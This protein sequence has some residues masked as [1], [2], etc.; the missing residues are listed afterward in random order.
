MNTRAFLL[1][2][3][4]AGVAIGLFG[5]LPIISLANCILCIWV[6]LGAMLAVWL[7]RKLEGS[8]P[9]LTATQGMLLGLVSG[10]IGAVIVWLLSL[11]T[12]D[13]ASDMI[14]SIATSAGIDLPAGLLGGGFTLIRLV[15]D[16][17][18]YSI[19]GVVGGLIGASVFKT[20]P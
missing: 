9:N 17:V 4:I 12:K 3:L 16:L 18:L 11:L 1:A 6:W 2:S 19:F 5:G 7:Y 8:K 13:A 15:I 20:K 14:A 10:V